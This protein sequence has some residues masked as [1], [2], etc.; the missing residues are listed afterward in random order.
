[1]SFTAVILAGGAGK[2]LAPLTDRVPKPALPFGSV[3]FVNDVPISNCLNSGVRQILVLCQHQP[4]KLLSHYESGWPII[5]HAKGEYIRAI[6]PIGHES[7]YTHT[8]HAVFQSLDMIDCGRD[9]RVLILSGDHIY[10]MDYHDID[11]FGRE[12]EASVVVAAI[13]VR[14]ELAHRFG[15]LEVN[16]NHQVI[17]FQEKPDEAKP[18]PHDPDFC[19]VSMGIYWWVGRDLKVDLTE[20]DNDR[21]SNHDFGSRVI[22]EKIR[23]GK[24]FAYPF[25]GYWEDVGLYR[26]YWGANMDLLS[27][28]PKFNLNDPTWPMHTRQ[29]QPQPSDISDRAVAN[30]LIIGNNCHVHDRAVVIKS[31]LSS[32]VIIHPNA[33]VIESVIGPKVVVE[34][35]ARIY[36]GMVGE[37]TIISAGSTIEAGH[38]DLRSENLKYDIH[39][40][41]VA[42]A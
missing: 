36:R 42:V 17:D 19:L 32:D 25:E 26:S 28:Q 29:I 2:R 15:V 7:I 18:L 34:E 31:L 13:K 14:R 4:Q 9:D 5:N 6:R 21:A 11:L 33:Q 8:A 38:M 30:G 1:M 35:G 3:F 20:D 40:G 27:A 41:I 23:T 10:K 22:P 16:D 24:V 12:K 37:G 39:G